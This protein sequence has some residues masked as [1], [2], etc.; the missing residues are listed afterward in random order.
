MRKNWAYVQ[1]PMWL[2]IREDHVCAEVTPPW[3]AATTDEYAGRVSRN[4]SI[5]EKNP[6][7]KLNYEFGAYELDDLVK[8]HPDLYE[9][10]K[11]LVGEGR[12]AL[13][14][15]TYNQPHGQALSL[16]GNIRELEEGT[17]LI[18]KLFGVRVKTHIMQEPDYTNQT[19]QL[20]CAFGM[21]YAGYG[22]FLHD[23]ITPMG[24]G[25]LPSLLYRWVGLDGTEVALAV[26]QN[27]QGVNY[28]RRIPL[29]VQTDERFVNFHIPDMDEF[30]VLDDREYVCL[31]QALE[32]QERSHPPVV[33]AKLQLPWSYVEGTD[34]ELLLFE[35]T[36]SET[37]LIRAETLSALLDDG[38]V[39]TGLAE[40]WLQWLRAQHHDALWHGAPEL[41][42]VSVKWC[43][44]AGSEAR[45]IVRSLLSKQW[46]RTSEKRP[47]KSA[48]RKQ[49]AYG[50]AVRLVSI[51]PTP[52]RGVTVV[53]WEGE[54]PHSLVGAGGREIRVQ[55]VEC[56]DGKQALLVPY[57]VGGIGES[58][59]V[60]DGRRV[61][62]PTETDE[63][64]SVRENF[65]FENPF[66]RAEVTAY[67][68]IARAEAPKG[69]DLIR[70]TGTRTVASTTEGL[71]R[72]VGEIEKHDSAQRWGWTKP[73]ETHFR[74]G[75]DAAGALTVVQKGCMHAYALSGYESFLKRGPVA[76]ILESEGTV[77]DIQVKRSTYLYR[78]LPWIEMEISC[79]FDHTV[80]DEYLEDANK[81]C[82]WWPNWYRDVLRCGIAGGSETPSRPEI[83][84][85]PVNWLD[86]DR[87][88]LGGGGFAIAFDRTMKCFRRSGRL[89]TVLAWGDDKG[90]F[91]NRNEPLVWRNVQ[92]L[93]LSGAMTYRFAL[94]L[95]PNDWR[96][97]GVPEWAFA[98]QRRPVAERVEAEEPSFEPWLSL[99]GE[100]IVATS[101]RR[102]GED[103]VVR[104]HEAHGGRHAL[105]TAIVRGKVAQARVTDLGGNPISDVT[106]FRI[107]EIRI[108][109]AATP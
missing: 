14:N 44:E 21:R 51:L 76:D 13:V 9:R 100:G 35:T 30:P 11:A 3:G 55:R 93:R 102:S 107:G 99:N 2:I 70:N 104:F 37:E 39:H 78:D 25:P 60:G 65:I 81:L 66:Y 18:E 101:V 75:L 97:D 42:A 103:L 67:G 106:P 12:L 86:V 68:G 8:K 50:R 45:G 34:G 10:M 72:I 73:D 57:E 31:D 38:S 20:M 71:R 33:E 46:K 61:D 74:Y 84:F 88:A 96:T 17:R 58:V 87:H 108:P 16:E 5:L 4:L 79:F 22:C 41:R 15:G 109:S 27:G 53:H 105:P 32:A 23:L 48:G 85:L 6:R 56:I 89:G 63:K 54:P 52:H 94:Y 69:K 98:F 92:D 19:P 40:L 82:I 90:H 7:V 77:G 91:N 62:G 47:S 1:H 95:H 80:I 64:A 43:R 26:D 24:I 29:E 59:L 36:K 83:G 49:R 28:D